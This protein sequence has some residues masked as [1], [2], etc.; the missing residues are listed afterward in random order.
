[1]A[2]AQGKVE[3]APLQNQAKELSATEAAVQNRF[4]ALGEAQQGNLAGIG[5]QAEAGAKTAANQAADNALKAGQSVETTG[6][7]Q[8]GLTGGFLSPEAKAEIAAEGQ[9]AAGT[10]AAGKS[11]AE[12]SGQN[13]NNLMSNLRAAAAAKVTEGAAGIANSYGKQLAVN[14]AK[15]G[16]VA[17][18]VATNFGKL[19]TELPQKAFNEK[20]TEAGLGIKTNTLAQ[21]AQETAAKNQVTERGQNAAN[22]RNRESVGQR[23]TASQRT[24]ATAASKQNFAEF[25]KKNEIGI[26]NLSAESKAKYERFKEKYTATGGKPGAGAA[27][28]KAQAV[29]YLNSVHYAN[30]VVQSELLAATKA[31]PGVPKA[32]LLQAIREKIQGGKSKL[33]VGK[34][35]PDNQLSGALNL[36]EY[37]TL[38]P[39]EKLEAKAA[40]GVNPAWFKNR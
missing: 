40:E 37:G 33:L 19:A 27:L 3:L 36:A 12:Q 28:T 25:T 22:A 10:G 32:K 34:T 5:A 6:Q 18:K 23:E 9:R 38:G 8:A 2:Q 29:K 30:S 35:L 13:E 4:K 1:M 21:K 17:G 15:Q 11:L 39:Q 26:K 20:A 31:N 14:Q 24:A 16:E 7:T